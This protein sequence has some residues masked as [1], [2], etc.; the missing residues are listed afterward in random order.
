MSRPCRHLPSTAKISLHRDLHKLRVANVRT[1][2]LDRKIDLLATCYQSAKAARLATAESRAQ[3][4]FAEHLK[5]Q[6]STNTSQAA[7]C[8]LQK[9][10]VSKNVPPYTTLGAALHVEQQCHSNTGVIQ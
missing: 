4:V 7:I 3:A 5:M 2:R 1:Y 6:G 9:A 8:L 10:A